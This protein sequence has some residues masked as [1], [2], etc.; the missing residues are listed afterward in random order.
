M[1]NTK[2]GRKNLTQSAGIHL[3]EGIMDKQSCQVEEDNGR[4]IW[5]LKRLNKSQNLDKLE[6]RKR[7]KMK[8]K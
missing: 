8:G 4:R 5:R 3:T 7:S 2:S 6:D 1:S